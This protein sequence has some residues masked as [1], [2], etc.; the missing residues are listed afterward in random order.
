VLAFYPAG[1]GDPQAAYKAVREARRGKTFLFTQEDPDSGARAQGSYGALRLEGES[2]I[3]VE[4]SLLD[5]EAVVKRLQSTGSPAVFVLHDVAAVPPVPTSPKSHQPI[6]ARLDDNARALDLAHRDL[7]EAVRLGHAVTAAAEWM[8]DNVY[9]VR[10]QIAE[11]RRNLPRDYSKKLSALTPGYD[12]A[13]DLVIRSDN[14][15]NESNILEWLEQSQKLHP[16][17]IA[18]LWFFPLLLRMALLEAL[19]NLASRVSD[20]QRLREAAYLW[21]NRLAASSR[22]GS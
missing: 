22:R 4:A 7:T 11:I 9:L 5:V 8:L 20:A 12:L 21:A 6:F 17:T 10:T 15:L 18:E 14:S 3:V 16:L 2:L 19:R 1:E 13:S